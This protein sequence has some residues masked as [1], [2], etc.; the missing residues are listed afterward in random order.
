METVYKVRR[1]EQISKDDFRAIQK[2]V[3]S[4]LTKEDA[5]EALGLSRVSL[6]N[7]LQRGTAKTKTIQLIREKLEQAARA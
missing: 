1:S 7:L 2:F 5:A 3:E 4:F 6:T